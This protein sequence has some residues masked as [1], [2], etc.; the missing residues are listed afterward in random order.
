MAKPRTLAN[1][2]AAGGPLENGDPTI[3]DVTGLQAALDAKQAALVSGTNIKTIGGQSVL[4]SGDL[5]LAS[6]G[7]NTFTTSS[8][9][10]AGAAVSLKTGGTVRASGVEPSIASTPVNLS[11]IA[12]YQPLVAYDSANGKYV[13]FYRQTN[14]NDLMGVVGTPSG[15]S[16]TL[17]TPVVIASNI[18]NV[19]CVSHDP[20]QNVF[21]I[22][23]QGTNSYQYAFC[24]AVSGSSI[25]VGGGH[26]YASR[27]SN[28]NWITYCPGRGCHVAFTTDDSINP[29]RGYVFTLFTSGNAAPSKS[30]LSDIGI[31]YPQGGKMAYNPNESK[32]RC[33]IRWAQVDQ[34]S[35]YYDFSVSGTGSGSSASW[36][37]DSSIGDYRWTDV[38]CV[39]DSVSGATLQFFNNGSIS[40]IQCVVHTSGGSRG[41]VTNMPSGYTPLLAQPNSVVTLNGQSNVLMRDASNY[42]YLVPFT[43]TGSSVSF[44]TPSAVLSDSI[45]NALMVVGSSPQTGLVYYT[46]AATSTAVGRLFVPA[47]SNISQ[48]VGIAKSS[49][50]SGAS[51]D[52]NTLGAVNA[53]VTGLTPG[54]TYYLDN[55]G[56]LTTASTTGVK[57]GRALGATQLLVTGGQG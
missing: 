6:S 22:G 43:I 10:T 2:V 38:G 24:C 11:T 36:N 19:Y 39:Y 17:G 48:F 32:A 21:L 52:V 8:N 3:A 42:V 57:V 27:I 7:T 47:A 5:A 53:Q 14:N 55:A 51:L 34:F 9:V 37:R 45:S 30:T 13:Y 50:S 12:G 16:I 15:N 54:S 41:S 56:A 44:G 31:D 46:S 26:L 20:V 18:N 25:T 23:V 1:S 4:G 29:S 49:V 28:T 35:Y 33:V 40:A